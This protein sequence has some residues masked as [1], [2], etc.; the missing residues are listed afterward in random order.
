MVVLYSK[1]VCQPCKATKRALD[2]KGIEYTE[3]DIT[4]N[5]EAR[6]HIMSLGY[7]QAPVVVTETES[8]SGFKPGKIVELAALTALAV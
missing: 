6:E 4:T 2:S 7:K 5:P 8:W 3:I 1:P